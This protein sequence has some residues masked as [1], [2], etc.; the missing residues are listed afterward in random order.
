MLVCSLLFAIG[1]LLLLASLGWINRRESGNR[2]IFTPLMLFCINELLLVWPATIYARAEGVSEDNYATLVV[3]AS[4][5]SFVAGYVM[6]RSKAKWSMSGPV[7]FWSQPLKQT[8][9]AS[10]L[11]AILL[12]SSLF[13]LSGFYLYQGLPPAVNAMLEFASKGYGAGI[14]ELLSE[15]RLELTKGHFFGGEY[16]GQGAIRVLL[17]TGWPYLAIVSLVFLFSRRR[18]EW[19]LISIATLLACVVYIGGEG[20][21]G[22]VL[23]ALITV[24]VAVSYYAKYRIRTMAYTGLMLF[25]GLIVLSLPQKLSKVAAAGGDW[26]D[27]VQQLSE[28][29]FT[30]NGINSIYVIEYMRSG[31]MEHRWGGIHSTDICAA[32][33]FVN[34]GIPFTYEL[35]M[36]QNPGAKATR[37]TL[38]SMT[39]LGSLYGDFGAIG[40]VVGYFLLGALTALCSQLLF[41]NE[42]SVMNIAYVG[43]SVMCLGQ[44]NLNGIVYCGVAYGVL[45]IVSRMYQFC[46]L[47]TAPASQ[48]QRPKLKQANLAT[49]RQRT[50][51]PV[52]PNQ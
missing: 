41:R 20:T 45:L 28:R 43:M 46:L 12:C 2:I 47:V 18:T 9:S 22:P 25:A 4:A 13:I 14:N 31:Y 10:H 3:L 24:M 11:L 38:S 26:R 19:Q 7:Y 48:T 34:S 36:L 52:K 29:L 32:L 27:A 35:F 17:R 37:T 42:K 44:L 21:R 5:F 16:R 1:A 40:A 50:H 51:M 49:V 33:P 23:W 15:R 6:L 39:Y 30:G 8:K